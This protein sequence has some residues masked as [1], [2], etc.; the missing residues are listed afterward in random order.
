M[1]A[2][3]G[4]LSRAAAVISLL[5]GETGGDLRLLLETGV[6]RYKKAAGKDGRKSAEIAFGLLR[7][8]EHLGMAGL[9]VARRNYMFDVVPVEHP[10]LASMLRALPQRIETLEKRSK[11]DTER[12]LG[13]T[14]ELTRRR[15]PPTMTRISRTS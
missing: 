9:F 13:M 15:R 11:G 6:S 4:H 14:E 10:D 8:A 12:L 1:A 2:A 7:A 5:E 3:F